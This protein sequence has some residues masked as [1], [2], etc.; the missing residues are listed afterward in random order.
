MDLNQAFESVKRITSSG[1]FKKKAFSMLDELSAAGLGDKEIGLILI[2]MAITAL[3]E[4]GVTPD[5]MH[6]LVDQILSERGVA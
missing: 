4:S 3:A 1:V 2:G 5:L 6:A